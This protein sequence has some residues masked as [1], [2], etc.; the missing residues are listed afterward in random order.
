[1][2]KQQVK[3][4][5][6]QSAKSWHGNPWWFALKT[7]S[8]QG[9]FQGKS[10]KAAKSEKVKCQ[11][12]VAKGLSPWDSEWYWAIRTLLWAINLFFCQILS[13]P[14]PSVWPLVRFLPQFCT[15]RSNFLQ[16]HS[17]VT[18]LHIPYFFPHR[19]WCADRVENLDNVT[20]H[21]V[22]WDFCSV[23]CDHQWQTEQGSNRRRGY[24]TIL[25]SSARGVTCDPQ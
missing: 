25:I 16:V 11:L 8:F 22:W 9:N 6:C 18:Y 15:D 1:M 4:P 5:R 3:K 21:H 10:E 24:C 14:P 13:L 20:P 7:T 2:K 19:K 23:W 17:K 12:A